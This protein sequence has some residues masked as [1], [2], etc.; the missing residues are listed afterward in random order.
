MS[1]PRRIIQTHRNED[2]GR[3]HRQSWIDQHP[4]YDYQFF[5][6]ARCHQFMAEH[7]PEL[8]PTYDKLP[9][10][11]QKSDLF[12]YAAIHE[13]GGIYTDVD[14]ICCAPLHSY[15]DLDTDQL[16]AGM[17]MTPAHCA[18]GIQHYTTY[19]CSPFQVLQWTFAASPRHP[20]L[21][22]VLQRIRFYVSQM[23]EAQLRDWSQALRFTLELTGPA[24]FTQVL[25]EFLT[26]T[27]EGRVA[28]LP[29]MVWG[30][31]PGEQTRPENVAQ[32]KVRHLFDGSWR[33]D[34]PPARPKPA[35]RYSIQL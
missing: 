12:R 18:P 16:I 1:I 27:R 30:A 20:A 10:P 34:R 32:V 7:A 33:P 25:N 26:G 28:V 17:E 3:A 29:R 22:L 15:L 5:D 31:Y 21:A 14:T 13:L 2:L 4:D 11:V 23:S 35:L 8:L 24:V 6:D 19:Y 9:L